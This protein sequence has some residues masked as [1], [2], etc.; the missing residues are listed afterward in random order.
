MPIRAC[1]TCS[2]DRLVFPK[3]GSSAFTC[4]DCAWQGT[5]KEY[6]SWSAWQQARST[7]KIVA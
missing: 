3:A 4:E 1:S 2:S 7:A 5:P 6:P